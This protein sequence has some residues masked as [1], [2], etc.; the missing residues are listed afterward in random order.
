MTADI[1]KWHKRTEPLTEGVWWMRNKTTKVPVLLNVQE[2][3]FQVFETPEYAYVG[4]LPPYPEEQIDETK[5]HHRTEPLTPGLWWVRGGHISPYVAA[6]LVQLNG[7]DCSVH[8][9]CQYARATG[10]EPPA[11]VSE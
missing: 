2:D 5:W 4:P 11:E 7:L 10:I 3:N 6:R 1:K 9:S 8:S